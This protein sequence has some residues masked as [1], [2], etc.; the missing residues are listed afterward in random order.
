MSREDFYKDIER[1]TIGL[2]DSFKFRCTMCGKCCIDR[3]DILLNA[4]D[5]FRMSKHMGIP[6]VE[7]LNSFCEFYVGGSSGIPIVRLRPE[8]PQKRC[9]LLHGK[10]CLVHEAKPSVCAMFPLGRYM[11]FDADNFT[12]DA[13]SKAS[14]QYI[15]QPISCGKKMDTHTVREWLSGFNMETEDEAYI[16]WNMAI[17]H[18]GPRLKKMKS[19]FGEITMELVYRATLI[20]LYL[21]YST[22]EE[23]LPQFENNITELVSQFSIIDASDP[24]GVMLP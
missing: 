8:G 6:P 19:M 1:M 22:D 13:V 16:K 7:F 17:S 10:K 5:L 23:F 12:P 24:N 9:P 14:V 3:E 21:N 20:A 15:L 18:I 11:K 2:D 4:M